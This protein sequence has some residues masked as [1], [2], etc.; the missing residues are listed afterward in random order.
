MNEKTTTFGI[1]DDFYTRFIL[2]QARLKSEQLLQ[3]LP[4]RTEENNTQLQ[5]TQPAEQQQ[6][7][8]QNIQQQTQQQTQHQQTHLE[9]HNA[10]QQ[11]RFNDLFN[12]QKDSKNHLYPD[13]DVSFSLD[14]ETSNVLEN[15]KQK[16]LPPAFGWKLASHN[17]KRLRSGFHK[18]YKYCLGVYQCPECDFKEAPRQPPKKKKFE[19]PQPPKMKCP[20]HSDR[21]LVHWSCECTMT[22]EETSRQWIV[23]HHGNHNHE[24]PPWKG[25]LD[26]SSQKK[27]QGLIMTAPE[28]SPFQLKLGSPTRAATSSINSCL[29]NLDR[30]SYERAKILQATGMRSTIADLANFSSNISKDFIKQECIT[31]RYPHIVMQDKET[32]LFQL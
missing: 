18:Q 6:T 21:L 24:R 26:P 20:I 5:Q 32:S 23:S 22:V 17:S 25:R 31:S 12:F 13:G 15:G 4:K 30:L 11:Q 28:L 29:G 14:K 27:L 7:K 1:D 16:V 3:L 8:Q 10:T 9:T 19:S 2:A